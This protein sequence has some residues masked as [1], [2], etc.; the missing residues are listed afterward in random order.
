MAALE[1]RK[2]KQL[3]HMARLLEKIEKHVSGR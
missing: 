1:C 3:Q 2:V